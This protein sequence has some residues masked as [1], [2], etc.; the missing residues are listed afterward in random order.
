MSA[1]DKEIEV[2][3]RIA[4]VEIPIRGIGVYE[5]RFSWRIYDIQTGEL[6]EKILPGENREIV[7][8]LDGDHVITGDFK[9]FSL[10]EKRE[11]QD[12]KEMKDFFGRDN[13]LPSF[14][15]TLPAS[16]EYT[17][18]FG[19]RGYEVFEPSRVVEKVV[20]RGERSIDVWNWNPNAVRGERSE[21]AGRLKR[22]YTFEFKADIVSDLIPLPEPSQV[23]SKYEVG[24]E[25]PNAFVVFDVQARRRLRKFTGYSEETHFF[26]L[27]G[28]GVL[29]VHSKGDERETIANATDLLDKGNAEYVKIESLQHADFV[30]N[31]PEDNPDNWLI[32]DN[33]DGQWWT[34]LLWYE[35]QPWR[36]GKTEVIPE[37]ETVSGPEDYNYEGVTQEVRVEGKVVKYNPNWEWESKE[38]TGEF[39]HCGF[40]GADV[41]FIKLDKKEGRKKSKL[42]FVDLATGKTKQTLD[43][44]YIQPFPVFPLPRNRYISKLNE[45][46]GVLF[47]YHPETEKYSVRGTA[48]I[49][50]LLPHSKRQKEIFVC[51]LDELFVEA[52]APIPKELVGIVAA[53]I[54][55]L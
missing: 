36:R 33:P 41:A 25:F 48:F 55:K 38:G 46:G 8:I 52:S 28:S 2:F 27:P 22:E 14:F 15:K 1:T 6:L 26:I 49:N 29:G 7:C 21:T 24:V 37:G 42:V 20:L 30:A 10:R 19:G 3:E 35:N 4:R 51:S 12:L 45:G 31:F 18:S 16:Q 50:F 13:P 9:L 23:L 11:V 17:Y 5:D 53:F 34:Y 39:C 32:L 43:V 47:E 54:E 40:H 44:P